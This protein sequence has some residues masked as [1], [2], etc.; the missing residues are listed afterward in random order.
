MRKP[1]IQLPLKFLKSPDNVKVVTAN[2]RL[3][4]ELRYC[5]DCQKTNHGD[6]VWAR[7]QIETYE[8]WLTS[9]YNDLGALDP[10]LA[11]RSVVPQNTLY[12]I[13][14]QQAPNAEVEMHV[15]SIINA[16]QLVWDVNLWVDWQGIRATENGQLC[17]DWFQRIRRLLSREQLITVAEIPQVLQQAI[18]RHSWQPLPI[19]T[20]GFDEPSVTQTNLFNALRSRGLCDDA[21]ENPQAPEHSKMR[22][23]NFASE[24]NELINLSMWVREKLADLG[25]SGSIGVVINGLEK[26][27]QLVKRC[28][29]NAFPELDDITR[30]VSI[31][32]GRPFKNTRLCFDFITLLRWTQEPLAS[33]ALLQ[34]AHSPYFPQLRLFRQ[35][36]SWFK[37]RVSIRN[38]R[39][40]MSREDRQVLSRVIQLCPQKTQS[41]M[42]YADASSLMLDLIRLCGFKQKPSDNLNGAIDLNA[43][44]EF[45]DIVN[46]VVQAAAILPRISW[47]RFI[48]LIQVIAGEQSVR[49]EK[50]DAPIQIMAR[51]PSAYLYFDALWVTGISDA[52]WPGLPRPN[53]FVPMQMQ[54]QAN[55][56]RVTHEQMLA[57]AEKLSN[58]WRG[59]ASE[60]VFSYFSET[61]KVRALPSNL[62]VDLVQPATEEGATESQP[63]VKHANLIE[64]GHPWSVHVVYDAI[65][66]YQQSFGSAFLRDEVRAS[67]RWL[68]DQAQCPFKSWAVHRAAIDKPPEPITRFPNAAQRGTIFH[69]VAENLLAL[70]RTQAGLA[71]LNEDTIQTTIETIFATKSETKFLPARF[72]RHEKERVKRW[73]KA[74]I[75][76]QLLRR[77]PFTV[78]ETEKKIKIELN[79]LTFTGY[80]DRI[81][82]TEALNEIVIDHKTSDNY[83]P[84]YWDPA[85]MHDTQMPMYA[86]GQDSC[87]GLAY[88]NIFPTSSGIKATWRGMSEWPPDN[89]AKELASGFEGIESFADVKHAWRKRLEEIVEQYLAGKADVEPINES[90]CKYCH[91]ENLCRIYEQK[92]D[93]DESTVGG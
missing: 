33:S 17:D 90:V 43:V 46:G 36:K 5:F 66:E 80:I 1:S 62:F 47:R 39:H 44:K 24:G 85:A 78:I 63:L 53:P 74:W 15:R 70:A 87:D 45:N 77:K 51:N 10:K 91:L 42:T 31:D 69:A 21:D 23:E 67:T 76:F 64:N 8:Q 38:Y 19:L 92:T 40:H 82:R 89:S 18:E 59:C 52:D 29:E 83:K 50:V 49:T 4:R 65:F 93:H 34:L 2:A 28:F 72:A 88:M 11:L 16:W 30:L 79:G 68:R 22:L 32:S 61:D 14:Q 60:I 71:L 26:N 56:P 37:D 6:T 86:T 27:Y 41:M 55:V 12:V 73:I 9:C 48:D 25:S 20:L 81:D 35:P 13:A 75:D 3:A 84:N 57:E 58:H 54:K 7:P